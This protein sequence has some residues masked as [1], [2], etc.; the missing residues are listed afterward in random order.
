[1]IN[2]V[3]DNIQFLPI[4]YTNIAAFFDKITL[5]TYIPIMKKVIFCNQ[6]EEPKIYETL[7]NGIII[8][9]EF[10]EFGHT[11]SAVLSYINNKGNLISTQRKKKL[12]FNEGGYYVE[13]AL[14]GKIIK[15]LTY[16]EALYI[17]NLNNYKKSLDEFRNG[18][19]FLKEESL[20]INGPFENLNIF[21]K[22]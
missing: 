19:E 14:F 10:H 20:R 9:I 8:E 21:N 16:E 17:L 15:T 5:T 7:E 13:M 11:I 1:M 18:F 3:V 4:N 6:N 2:Y 12:K 22:L